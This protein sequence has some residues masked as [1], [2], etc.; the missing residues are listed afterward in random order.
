M[1]DNIK[2]SYILPR[3]SYSAISPILPPTSPLASKKARPHKV[4]LVNLNDKK[5]E[6]NKRSEV[7]N[8]RGMMHKHKDYQGRRIQVKEIKKKNGT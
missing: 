4:K 2:A 1:R 5:K 6:E 3:S 8:I 7:K